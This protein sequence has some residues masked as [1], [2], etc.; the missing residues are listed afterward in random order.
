MCSQAATMLTTWTQLPASDVLTVW[1]Q[2]RL[3]QPWQHLAQP[4]PA[5]QA[6]T[7]LQVGCSLLWAGDWQGLVSQQCLTW[8]LYACVSSTKSRT[9]HDPNSLWSAKIF[10]EMRWIAALLTL[11]V[12]LVFWLQWV[13][14]HKEHFGYFSRH[15]EKDCSKNYSTLLNT[16]N[17]LQK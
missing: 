4:D 12:I 15:I 5:K 7:S 13:S 14:V 3:A 8:F 6:A 16:S 17:V 1:A 11:R 9:S 2:L 10:A